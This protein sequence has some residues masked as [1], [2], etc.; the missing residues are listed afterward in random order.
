MTIPVKIPSFRKA[1]E[2]YDPD[3]L[4]SAFKELRLY[5][6]L[7]NAKGNIEA[8]GINA[9]LP[10]STDGAGLRPGTFYR[11]ADGTVKVAT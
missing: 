3:F 7:L 2:K 6:Q 9:S 5:M 8:A 10:E 11:L 4:D 1:P